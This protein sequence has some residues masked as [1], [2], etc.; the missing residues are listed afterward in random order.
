VRND[1]SADYLTSLVREL[2]AQPRETEWVEFKRELMPTPQ[3]IGEYVS[4]LANAA[5]LVGQALSNGYLVWGVRMTPIPPLW[6]GPE[7]DPGARAKGS[8]ES[9]QAGC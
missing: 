9:R 4:A 1:R 8:Q 3:A 2:C 5:A 6:L 7:F